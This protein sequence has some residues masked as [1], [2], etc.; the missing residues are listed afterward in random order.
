MNTQITIPNTPEAWDERATLPTSHE[1]AMW[2][3]VGQHY[4]FMN[5]LAELRLSRDSTDSLFDFGC[6]TGKFSQHLPSMVDY[7]GYDWSPNMV[8]RAA[9]N[10][11]AA[12]RRFLNEV[13]AQEFD[14]I[15]ALGP[16]NL[17]DGWPKEKTWECL[18]ALWELTTKRLVASLWTGDQESKPQMLSYS[19][20]ELHAFANNLGAQNRVYL[21]RANDIMLVMD[22]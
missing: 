13:P 2:S 1:A 5:T 8:A 9:L 10:Y 22:R 21:A 4:R 18:T 7:V 3:A 6:G 19:I 14:Y 20:Q 16:F 11:K 12:N 15:I 17:S